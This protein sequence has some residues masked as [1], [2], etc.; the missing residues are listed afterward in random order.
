M[1]LKSIELAT[2]T[3]VNKIQE[4]AKPIETQEAIAQVASIQLMIKR[5][6]T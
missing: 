1:F 2:Q 5:S 3:A 6:V 4:V